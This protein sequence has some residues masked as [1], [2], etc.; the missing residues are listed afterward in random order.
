MIPID[1][2]G[3]IRG[4]FFAPVAVGRV[5]VR[6]ASMDGDGATGAVLGHLTALVYRRSDPSSRCP[7]VPEPPV[8]P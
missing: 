6:V 7:D 8:I 2:A 5:R 4:D 3:F 1:A